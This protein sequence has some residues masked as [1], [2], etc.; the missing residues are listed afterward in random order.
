MLALTEL[1]S[2]LDQQATR[3]EHQQEQ[4]REQREAIE[5]F[6]K[7]SKRSTGI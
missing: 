7:S 3:I 2:K 4:L 6:G 5:A 1:F